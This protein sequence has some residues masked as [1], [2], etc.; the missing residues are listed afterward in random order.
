MPGMTPRRLRLW[1]DPSRLTGFDAENAL[2][3]AR[4]RL[5]QLRNDIELMHI[6]QR[7]ASSIETVLLVAPSVR[8]EDIDEIVSVLRESLQIGAGPYALMPDADGDEDDR[9]RGIGGQGPTCPCC[10]APDGSHLPKC[11]RSPR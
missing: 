10:G 8:S 3:E 11:P 4:R 2:E 9:G 1:G 6:E 5:R 7:S